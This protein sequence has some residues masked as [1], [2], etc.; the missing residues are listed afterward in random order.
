MKIN[1]PTETMEEVIKSLE[2]KNQASTRF[3]G[4]DFHFKKERFSF[5]AGKTPNFSAVLEKLD[6]KAEK[7]IRHEA[8]SKSFTFATIGRV[9]QEEN[10]GSGTVVYIY[11]F[12]NEKANT[13]FPDEL[14]SQ[15]ELHTW[16]ETIK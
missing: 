10:L 9:W 11:F 6:R 2:I 3:N 12:S 5:N 13:V 7:V 14:V 8:A 1:L 4:Q 16:T 15:Y